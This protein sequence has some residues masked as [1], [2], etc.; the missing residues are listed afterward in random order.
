MLNFAHRNFFTSFCDLKVILTLF[1]Y[2]RLKASDSHP[3]MPHKLISY[4]VVFASVCCLFV[5]CHRA[6]ICCHSS[7]PPPPRPRPPSLPAS[8]SLI[9]SA[10]DAHKVNYHWQLID[11]NLERICKMIQKR[12]VCVGVCD[13]CKLWS[14]SNFQSAFPAVACN[15]QMLLPPPAASQTQ[16]IN[17]VLIACKLTVVY[18]EIREKQANKQHLHTRFISADQWQRLQLWLF[19]RWCHGPR[20]IRAGDEAHPVCSWVSWQKCSW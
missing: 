5:V 1:P 9:N 19:G 11:I 16:Q 15:S 20:P 3:Y 10:D 2:R 6:I 12:C 4:F 13:W 7:S 8:L 17:T 14:H 18:W